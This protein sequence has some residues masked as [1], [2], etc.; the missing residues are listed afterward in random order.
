M[1][2]IYSMCVVYRDNV[3]SIKKTFVRKDSALE[4]FHGFLQT[5][6]RPVTITFYSGLVPNWVFTQN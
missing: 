5:N 4:W 3:T 1:K 6:K 2:I